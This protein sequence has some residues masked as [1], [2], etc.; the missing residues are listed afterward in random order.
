M[1]DK[2]IKI[3]NVKINIVSRQEVLE[4][5]KK[6]L[7]TERQKQLGTTNP[8]FILE[9]QKN[10]KF[11][12]II[13]NCWLSVA[14]GYGIQLAAKYVQEL[15]NKNLKFKNS[16]FKRI[17][18]GLKVAWWGITRNNQKLDV[19]TEVITGTDLV[20]EICKILETR[21]PFSSSTSSEL[22]RGKEIKRRVFLLGGFG[23]IPQLAAKKLKEKFPQVEIG[24]SVFEME[25]IIEIINNFEPEILFV[26]LNY[27][28]AQMWIAENLSKMPSV[29]LA[30]GVG[31]ALDYISG[32][33][34]RAP[35]KYQ[36][37]YEWL[38]RLICQPR[39]RCKRIW[40][41]VVV[42]PWQVFRN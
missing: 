22:R 5:I 20:P 37:S 18:I 42:F 32:Q 17:L 39:K 7:E 10:E 41:A 31:G 38:F 28:R 4:E 19:I 27:P 25:D 6:L 16:F 40:R 34:K 21:T 23:E 33:I 24:Y 1:N 3:L 14:D 2:L 36:H 35:V 26:A 30:V 15:K 29:K 9:A 8:E 12:E 13:N 11:R